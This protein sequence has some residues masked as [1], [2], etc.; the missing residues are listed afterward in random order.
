M[1]IKSVGSS[2]RFTKQI[3]QGEWRM[4]ELTASGDVEEFDN[5]HEAQQDLFYD[6]S[7]QLK[8]LWDGENNRNGH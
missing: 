3:A 2:V 4:V 6:L 7:A 8:R 1:K 5:W